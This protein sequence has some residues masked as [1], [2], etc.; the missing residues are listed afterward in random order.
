M[1]NLKILNLDKNPIIY[2][3]KSFSV[4]VKDLDKFILSNNL[5]LFYLSQNLKSLTNQLFVNKTDLICIYLRENNISRI[6]VN[7]LKSLGAV[8]YLYLSNNELTTIENYYFNYLNNLSFLF[9]DSNKIKYIEKNSFDNLTKLTHLYLFKN[10]LKFI[11]KDL[12]VKL[13]RLFLLDLT[14]ILVIYQGFRIKQ[15]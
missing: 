15:C 3:D 7:T 4:R 14:I 8:T 10:D 9:L 11:E 6:E 1:T 12:F 5:T 13:N 2:F